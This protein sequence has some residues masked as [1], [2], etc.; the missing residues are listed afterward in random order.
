ML[1][2][3]PKLALVGL[4]FSSISG[5]MSDP[6]KFSARI[7]VFERPI[8]MLRIDGDMTGQTSHIGVT[9]TDFKL[10]EAQINAVR[11]LVESEKLFELD[12]H[13]GKKTDGFVERSLY[14]ELG[15]KQK[16]IRLEGP[17]PKTDPKNAEVERI[18]KVWKAVSD[19][20]AEKAFKWK[21]ADGDAGS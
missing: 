15:D 7:C 10:T 17:L 20:N 11:N 2:H 14:L 13:Y 1:R 8:W 6:P 12:N 9:R 19:L 3:L 4:L 16:E 21:R 18:L 5:C